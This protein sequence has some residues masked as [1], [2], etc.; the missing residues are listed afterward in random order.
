MSGWRRQDIASRMS[1]GTNRRP[2]LR[3]GIACAT[4][5]AGQSTVSPSKFQIVVVKKGYA[6]FVSPPLTLKE[7]TTEKFEVVDPIRLEPG[8][9]ISG[10]VVD[11]RGHPVAGARVRT[12]RP[13]PHAGLA[14]NIP[15]VRADENGRFT[16][17]DLQPGMTLLTA[18]DGILIG[19]PRYVR[20]GSSQ[21]VLLQL[22]EPRIDRDAP[23]RLWPRDPSRSG[24]VKPPWNGKWA[25]GPTAEPTILPIIGVKP[26]CSI[27]GGLISGKVSP[28]SRRLASSPPNSSRAASCFGPSTDRTAMR[29]ASGK[30]YGSYSL[31]SKRRSSLRSTRFRSTVIPA[32]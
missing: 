12:N 18:Y 15:T 22:P 29:N 1:F 3:D 23:V 20:V 24:W 25:S 4:S 16:M 21:S 8:V 10:I 9:T 6:G 2:T 32:A 27:S 13:V 7:G 14:E 26:S 19:S 5:L 31:P 28:H 17:H 30:K 11:H